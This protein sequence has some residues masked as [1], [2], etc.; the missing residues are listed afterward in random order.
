MAEIK[1]NR[2]RSSKQT[3]KIVISGLARSG[4]SSVTFQL[5]T[6][7]L[8]GKDF[9]YHANIDYTVIEKT[10]NDLEIKIFDL[11]GQTAFMDRYT[12]ELAEFI[13]KETTAA[14]FV[15][16][17]IDTQGISRAK[18]Y[19]D[20]ERRILKKYSPE[21]RIYIFLNKIDL[22]PS[23]L[24]R[25]VVETVQEYLSTNHDDSPKIKYM[26][27]SL[28]NTRIFNVFDLILK[29][30][31]NNYSV[32]I[33]LDE[34]KKELWALDDQ[35]LQKRVKEILYGSSDNVFRVGRE[36]ILLKERLVTL[37]A[38][39]EPIVQEVLKKTS[40]A[41]HEAESLESDKDIINNIKMAFFRTGEFEQ[42]L[43]S[44]L[45]FE[46]GKR[47]WD[48][49]PVFDQLLNE[50]IKEIVHEKINMEERINQ[51]L[52]KGFWIPTQFK[53]PEELRL[54]PVDFYGF[55]N[56]EVVNQ[57]DTITLKGL[58]KQYAT[59]KLINQSNL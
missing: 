21:T 45:I 20:L 30:I 15:V 24:K 7:C 40:I 56:S 8:F 32:N 48:I 10:V 54:D 25:E 41:I 26:V 44:L 11:A 37:L 39:L 36:L 5:V 59:Q 55:I 18:Y 57:L 50:A 19:L 35:E 12:G 1:R 31:L 2:K 53:H 28:F 49:V 29:D 4:A 13:F 23:E 42:M 27:T 14:I 17:L 58:L 33:S 22:V 47:A 6:G 34:F 3:I 51:F 46:V 16:D 43:K 9:S 52:S 38:V